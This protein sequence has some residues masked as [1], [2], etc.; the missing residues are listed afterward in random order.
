V[1]MVGVSSPV[2]SLSIY[3][4]PRHVVRPVKITALAGVSIEALQDFNYFAQFVLLPDPAG[5]RFTTGDADRPPKHPA[6]MGTTE[7]C[8]LTR[9]RPLLNAGWAANHHKHE[10]FAAKVL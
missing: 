10:P 2:P 5:G 6:V 4:L 1:A 9:S 8:G 3:G 7:L